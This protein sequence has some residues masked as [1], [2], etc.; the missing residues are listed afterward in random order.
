MKN[1]ILI[2]FIL[3]G[4]TVCAQKTE[5]KKL[6]LVIDKSIK[7]IVES[8]VKKSKYSRDFGGFLIYETPET[9]EFFVN[10]SLAMST[11]GDKAD[12]F[13]SFYYEKND[14]ISIDGAFGLFGGFGFSIKLID[15]KPFVYTLMAADEIP[16]YSL[17]KSDS[18]EL[19]I[20]VSCKN[21]KL[22]LS[23]QPKLKSEEIV[24]GY[25]EFESSE[26][27]QGNPIFGRKETQER[28]KLKMNMKVYFKSKFIDI[29]KMD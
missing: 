19:R 13:K 9:V 12:L 18:L 20:E 3:F 7:D 4:I 16:I 29:E 1:K 24:Y 21:V 11:N 28:I 5:S 6:E 14:T 8:K 26:F 2:L 17:T 22:I 25:L 15:K 23:K 10:D 27:Y